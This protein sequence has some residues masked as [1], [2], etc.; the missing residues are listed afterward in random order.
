VSVVYEELTGRNAGFV[1]EV[2]QATLRSSRVLVCGVGGMG[3]AAAH[4]LARV[5]VGRLTITDPDFFDASNLNRQTFANIDTLGAPKAEATRAALLRINPTLDVR[6]VGANW[7]ECLDEL[8][9]EHGVVVNA[10]DDPRAGIQLY[11]EARAWGVTVV[12]AYTSPYPSV[13]AVGPEDPRPEE[14]LEFATVG[15]PAADIT[16][17]QLRDAFLAELDYV[18][19]VSTGIGR[20]DPRVVAEIIEGGRPRSS[21][22]PVVTI[23]GNLMAFEAIGCLL[24]RPSGAGPEGYFVDL[25]SGRIE[26]PSATPGRG[27]RT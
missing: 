11:R 19:R 2:E 24:G 13:T 26:R 14:R 25:W 5:G 6:V 27:D 23:A 9:A 16:T 3:G 22:C 8:L 21:F 10:M 12:D 1:T 17:E 15:V 18:S 4:T 20:L 7:V